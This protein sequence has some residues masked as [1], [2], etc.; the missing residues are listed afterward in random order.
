MQCLVLPMYPN[1]APKTE[2]ALGLDQTFV[3]RHV[4]KCVRTLEAP[5]PLLLLLLVDP[6]V[7]LSPVVRSGCHATATFVLLGNDRRLDGPGDAMRAWV[8]GKF[9]LGRTA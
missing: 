5:N 9:K 4:V 7:L 8:V 3:V 6:A 1:P 2:R